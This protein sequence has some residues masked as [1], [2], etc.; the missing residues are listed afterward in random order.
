MQGVRKLLK[1]CEECEEWPEGHRSDPS[2]WK[3][4]I[5]AAQ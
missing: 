1:V 2:D 3:M 4:L 5:T